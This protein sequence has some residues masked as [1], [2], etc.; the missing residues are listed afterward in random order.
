MENQVNTEKIL[1]EEQTQNSKNLPQISVPFSSV[2]QSSLT[3]CDPMDCS[4]PG[5]PVHHQLP[6]LARI[7]VHR[8][9][10]TI[11]T[12]HPLS[13]PFP[14][15]INLSHTRVFSKESFLP[16]RWPNYWSFTFSVIPSNEYSG[17][18]SFRMNSLDPLAVQGF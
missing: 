13:F 15:A 8:V 2:T 1:P 6:E 14:P 18:I 9:G 7:H 16:I 4:M 10:D 11:Q 12:S 17:L 5:S 3:L